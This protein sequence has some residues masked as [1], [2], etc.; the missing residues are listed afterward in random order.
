M[1][2]HFFIWEQN[3]VL[4][5]IYEIADSFWE[6]GAT[7]K[8]LLD[9]YNWRHKANKLNTQNIAHYCKAKLEKRGF[10]V[11]TIVNSTSEKK[12]YVTHHYFKFLMK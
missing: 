7:Y 2:E 8:Q 3:E 11:S 5:K 6:N 1:L 9:E 4:Y 10:L 12:V